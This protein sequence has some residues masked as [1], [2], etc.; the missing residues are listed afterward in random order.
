MEGLQKNT[1]VQST[2]TQQFVI[3][4]LYVKHIAFDLPSAPALFKKTE[5]P[6]INFEL[7]VHNTL[8]EEKNH[9]DVTL[10]VTAQVT[11]ADEEKAF[12]VTVKQSGVFLLEG[13][14][15]EQVDQLLNNYCP[16]VLFPYLR[17][18]ISDTAVRGGLMPLVMA[19]I[20]FDALYTQKKQQEKEQAQKTASLSNAVASSIETVQ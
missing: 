20:N 7:G 14:D 1:S 8:L 16:S 6:K 10:S 12:D 3:Q 17:E 11:F 15:A 18:V 13:Y 2:S 5:Q 9:Y 19:P 4:K